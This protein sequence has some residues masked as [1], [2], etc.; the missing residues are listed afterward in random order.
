M[1]TKEDESENE[2]R[3]R[4]RERE[5]IKLFNNQGFMKLAK[6]RETFILILIVSLIL[7]AVVS[8]ITLL[9]SSIVNEVFNYNY[10]SW[11]LLGE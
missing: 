11:V 10:W 3:R 7:I 1:T 8:L 2:L 6:S 4:D 5:L 9:F